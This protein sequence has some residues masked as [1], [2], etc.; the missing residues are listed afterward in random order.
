MLTPML[1]SIVLVT[2]DPSDG[3]THQGECSASRTRGAV[4]LVVL[5]GMIEQLWTNME[6]AGV[7]RHVLT[8]P[9]D[10]KDLDAKCAEIMNNISCATDG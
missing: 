4:S 7:A 6:Q 5:S 3:K 10:W 8:A 2:R 9:D 1:A